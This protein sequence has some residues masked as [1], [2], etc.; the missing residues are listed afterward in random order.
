M[1]FCLL[2]QMNKL[3][4]NNN[5]FTLLELT[6]V[7]AIIIVITTLALS[8]SLNYKEHHLIAEAHLLR[9]TIW[10]LQQQCRAENKNLALIFNE[11]ENSY[12]T[13]HEKHKL[14][15]HVKFG[16]L[17][18]FLDHHHRQKN[19]YANLLPSKIKK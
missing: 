19:G 6:I 10:H 8:I 15:S 17:Q 2:R 3:K 13:P 14:S 18:I 12:S 4:R 16:T 9:T 1:K 5:G 11:E 7:L